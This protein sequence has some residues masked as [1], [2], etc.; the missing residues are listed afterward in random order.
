MSYIR[1]S[2]FSVAV[3]FVFVFPLKSLEIDLLV[4]W[5]QTFS[6]S[7]DSLPFTWQKMQLLLKYMFTSN[8]KV[9]AVD[10]KKM[11]KLYISD[12]SFRFEVLSKL[13]VINVLQTGSNN[14][15][16]RTQKLYQTGIS[17]VIFDRGTNTMHFKTIVS[18][19]I[20]LFDYN[21]Y[22]FQLQIGN[23]VEFV[24]NR[25]KDIY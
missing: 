11:A 17:V 15:C 8:P 12:W 23:C 20:P 22:F 24:T 25:S 18:F 7:L 3:F 10:G 19:F 2:N 6:F 14:V 4:K 1:K 5:V 9:Y 21:Q 16:R 13:L